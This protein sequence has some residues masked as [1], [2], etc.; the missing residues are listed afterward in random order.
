MIGLVALPGGRLW[1]VL[2]ILLIVGS[3]GSCLVVFV[4]VA[5]RQNRAFIARLRRQLDVGLRSVNKR[6]KESARGRDGGLRVS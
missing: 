1:E 4:H 2:L 6:M 3:I 5:Y